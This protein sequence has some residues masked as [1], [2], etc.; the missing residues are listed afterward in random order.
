MFRGRTAP[1]FRVPGTQQSEVRGIYLF[2]K[3]LLCLKVFFLK[4]KFTSDRFDGLRQ[5]CKMLP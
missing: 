2:F 1:T 3:V 4:T 5:L